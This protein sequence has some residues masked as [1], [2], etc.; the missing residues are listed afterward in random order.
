MTLEASI[1]TGTRPVSANLSPLDA[2]KSGPSCGSRRW[3]AVPRVAA[4]TQG[5][6]DL[7]ARPGPKSCSPLAD[8]ARN[9]HRARRVTL[10]SVEA[11]A[12]A[13][14]HDGHGRGP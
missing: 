14:V 9:R 6:C 5:G 1:E 7:Q 8:S 10:R 13:Q 12:G 3:P 11:G 4:S 2:W